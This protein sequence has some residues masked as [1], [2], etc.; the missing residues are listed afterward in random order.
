MKRIVLGV[1]AL[2]AMLG[3][4]PVAYAAAPVLDN[5][6][7]YSVSWANNDIITANSSDFT[8]NPNTWV[9]DTGAVSVDQDEKSYGQFFACDGAIA[10][11]SVNAIGATVDMDARTPVS[12]SIPGGIT[13]TSFQDGGTSL[14]NVASATMMTTS[15]T[16]N[17]G[18]TSYFDVWTAGYKHIGFVQ[19]VNVVNDNQYTSGDYATITATHQYSWP[20]IIGGGGG[21]PTVTQQPTVALSG[22]Q[23]TI[24]NASWSSGTGVV[25][26]YVCTSPLATAI[27]TPASSP[28][29][30]NCGPIYATSNSSDNTAATDFTSAFVNGVSGRIPWVSAMG[31]NVMAY[32][33]NTTSNECVATATIAYV[34]G[35]TPT[36]A[37]PT[38]YVG[39]T[40][41]M[42][43][44]SIA[45]GAGDDVTIKG[46]K[47]ETV[48]D[49]EVGKI[50]AEFSTT[51]SSLTLTVPTELEIGTHD[52]DMT[53]S[54]GKITIQD[55]VRVT[56]TAT[57]VS[58]EFFKVWTKLQSGNKVKMHA[59]NPMGEGKIQF[60][61]NGE[62]IAW[63]N[64]VDETDPKLNS[65]NGASY[66]VRTVDLEPGKNRFEI[67]QDGQRI[68]FATYV[69]K[70]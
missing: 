69:P 10:T 45:A 38:P 35:S 46:D 55:A 16:T 19:L 31:T 21:S 8:Y 4:S 5:P 59:K 36:Q 15:I 9:L 54:F 37:A 34:A 56:K 67:K 24:T 49:V 53:S 3:I 27:T 22:S 26:T 28:S 25:A 33:C 1:S 14:V 23:I 7:N 13:C 39:P 20:L 42:S 64:A 58:E 30:G 32:A 6:A 65:A 70:G 48:S 40:L 57:I 18:S 11:T 29:I 2:I 43:T 51:P 44:G 68:W 50:D 41:L 17:I 12:F 61:V 47:L 63:V 62:E 52:I 66:L 60:L